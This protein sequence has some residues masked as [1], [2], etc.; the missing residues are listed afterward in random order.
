MMA[1][2]GPASG[3]GW[4]DYQPAT[5]SG[6]TAKHAG[7]FSDEDIPQGA[8]VRNFHAGGDPFRATVVFMGEMRSIGPERNAFIQM[9]G[10][11]SGIDPA[12][13]AGTFQKEIEVR[14]NQKTYWL[15]IQNVLIPHLKKEVGANREATLFV[16][17]IGAT[18]RDRVFLVNEF[19][20]P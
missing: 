13:L 14:E 2:A 15:P 19:Q 5:L 12:L 9:W 1:F 8:V 17:F 4:D 20:A 7:H 6:I 16:V 10:K 11:A 3:S 18:E